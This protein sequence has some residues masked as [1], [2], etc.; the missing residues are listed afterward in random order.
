[1]KSVSNLVKQELRHMDAYD[2]ATTDQQMEL[3]KKIYHFV[4]PSV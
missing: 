3:L 2:G 4:F 1:M